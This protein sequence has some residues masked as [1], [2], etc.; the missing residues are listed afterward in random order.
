MARRERGHSGSSVRNLC[1]LRTPQRRRVRRWR[2]CTRGERGQSVAA[3]CSDARVFEHG[4][5]LARH[6]DLGGGFGR[7]RAL[8]TMILLM[9]AATAAIGLQLAARV[10]RAGPCARSVPSWVFPGPLSAINSAVPGSPCVAT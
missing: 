3:P 5:A 1:L 7:R 6:R 8:A 2:A 10:R 4:I 9:A